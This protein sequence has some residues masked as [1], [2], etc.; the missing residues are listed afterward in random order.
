[1]GAGVTAD[2]ARI[3]RIEM[4]L[5]IAPGIAGEIP[6]IL[7]PG[8]GLLV[9]DNGDG[10]F[11]LDDGDSGALVD[12]GDGTFTVTSDAVVDNGDGTW[13]VTG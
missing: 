7:L 11:T 9:T 12:N 10:T 4:R 1:M 3:T 8:G 5:G 6:V 2:S 13:L